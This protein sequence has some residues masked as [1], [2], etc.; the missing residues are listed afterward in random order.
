M[1]KRRSIFQP[2]IFRGKLAMSFRCGV[3]VEE[4]CNVSINNS[5]PSWCWDEFLK[6]RH[7]F[8]F[9]DFKGCNRILRFLK[10]FWGLPLLWVGRLLSFLS[11]AK[12]SCIPIAS[13]PDW[14]EGGE[15]V[16]GIRDIFELSRTWCCNC[17]LFPSVRERFYNH[18][19]PSIFFHSPSKNDGWKT[20]L[21]FRGKAY[22]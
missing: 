15:L 13:L 10:S 19:T 20:S 6:P 11:Q 2:S 16:E 8:V 22:F 17:N 21:S 7:L 1:T 14:A 4:R 5:Q 9:G 12:T 18:S 3:E